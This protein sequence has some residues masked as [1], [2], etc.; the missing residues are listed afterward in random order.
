MT[1]VSSDDLVASIKRTT[2][3][4]LISH[5][6]TT[7]LYDL[8]EAYLF[9]LT[10]DAAESIGLTVHFRVADGTPAKELVLRT[11]PSAISRQAA[12]ARPQD[13]F[14]HAEL[15]R[16]GKPMLEVHLGVYIQS[17]STVSHEADVGVIDANEATHARATGTNPRASKTIL[18]LEAKCYGTNL[19]LHIGR[20]FLGLGEEFHRSKDILVANS[21]SRSVHSMLSH[22]KRRTHLDLIPAS[23]EET[24]LKSA[25]TIKLKDYLASHP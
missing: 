24:L 21:P 15:R 25:I 8:Y 1:V 10:V 7:K 22:R 12:A 23:D 2:N 9:G 4:P 5:S 11:S 16:S 3:I 6:T 14:T 17:S 20:E 13:L 19:P 18:M